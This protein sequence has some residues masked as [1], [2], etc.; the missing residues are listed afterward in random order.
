MADDLT[1]DNL[2]PPT[3]DLVP[4]ASDVLPPTG[5]ALPPTGDALPPTGD[6]I[7]PPGEQ[8]APST[9]IIPEEYASHER[10]SQAKSIE[11]LCKTIVNQETLIGKKYV[12][13]PD[14]KSTPEEIAK[15][16]E[17][18]GVPVSFEDYQLESSPEVKQLYGEADAEA[19]LGF[20]K[21]LHEAGVS[22]KQ[23]DILKKGYDGVIGGMME[24]QQAK[25]VALNTEF[26]KV[27]TDAFGA[28]KDA[29]IQV[30]RE[31]MTAKIS[32]N[33]KPHLTHVLQD[34]KALA[35]IADI[36]NNLYPELQPEDLRKVPD[37]PSGGGGDMATLQSEMNAFIADPAFSNDRDPRHD[38]VKAGWLAKAKQI[39][40]LKATK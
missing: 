12:G 36:A 31:F 3:G 13:I 21:I 28:E 9:F 33:L 15:F 11:D 25:I 29:K 7:T 4:P 24:Q 32:D 38:E 34:A 23:A 10:V 8:G 20:K 40:A 26:D 14:D 6:D 18:L 30:A 37:G 19:M 27:I 16:N 5:D 22:T 17:A 35:V 1:N 39:D 2:T